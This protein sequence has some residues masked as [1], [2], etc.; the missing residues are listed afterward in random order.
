M[1][2]I[3][4]AQSK[5]A[6]AIAQV[7]VETWRNTYAGCL[8]DSKLAR[9]SFK[10]QC[11]SWSRTLASRN[12][13]VVLENDGEVVGFGSCDYNKLRWLDYSG[14]IYT[15]YL[16]PDFH[17]CGFGRQLMKALF[18]VLIGRNYDSALLWVLAENPT[19]FFYEAMGGRCIAERNERI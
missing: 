3:R 18:D 6:Q 15:L 8:P 4:L 13:V 17:G 7:Y 10:R 14:E 2:N 12:Q 9:M 16:L 19:R 1:A 11:A 5:D